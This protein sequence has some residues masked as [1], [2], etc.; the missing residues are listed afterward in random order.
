MTPSIRLVITDLDNTLYDWVS[1]F[2]PAFYAMVDVAV[3]TLDV[4]RDTLLDE[5]Q[6]V[7]QRYHNSEQPFA[8]LETPA[9]ATRF[10]GKD[11]KELRRLLDPAFRAFNEVRDDTLRLYPGVLDTLRTLRAGGVAVVGHTEAKMTNGVYRAQILGLFEVLSKVYAPASSGLERPD[12]PVAA[13]Q[14]VV[15]RFV[16]ILP[17]DHRK[18]DPSVLLDICREHHV[19]PTQTLYVGDSLTRDIFMANRAG[20]RSA[21]ARYGSIYDKT[22]WADLVRVTHWTSEDVA[23]EARLKEETEGVEPDLELER[24][25]DLLQAFDF[26]DG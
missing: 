26:D 21:W 2:V 10:P 23:R 8:L 19:E 12:G 22:L 18:P 4:D 5:L 7:H 24:F 15:D 9:V 1:F 20:A 13:F 11:R 14:E 17:S 3:Q 25:S 6:V 16:T